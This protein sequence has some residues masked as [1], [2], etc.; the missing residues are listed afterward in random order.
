M[1]K[2]KLFDTYYSNNLKPHFYLILLKL[3]KIIMKTDIK[4][5]QIYKF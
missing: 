1:L 3:N 5:Q 4:G 2:G